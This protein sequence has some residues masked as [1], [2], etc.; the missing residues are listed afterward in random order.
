MG[1]IRAW[2][3][4]NTID[5]LS[6]FQIFKLLKEFGSPENVLGSKTKEIS[7]C[8]GISEEQ[9]NKVMSQL[10]EMDVEREIEK[11]R[12]LGIKILTIEDPS[13]PSYLKEI[14]DPPIL[15]YVKG[16][17]GE[18]LRIGI[19]GSRKAT[20]YGK[21]TSK[22]FAED[23]VS[24]GV[25]I[26]SGMARGIDTFAHLGALEGGGRT[27]AVLGCGIDVP[28]PPENRSLAERISSH[29][30]LVSE[31]L[32]GTRPLR[33]NF[34]RRNRIIAGLCLGLV[35]VEADKKSGALISANLAAEYG[36]EVF[37]VPGR[38]NTRQSNGTNA[39]IQDGAKL[40]R[41]A[42]EVLEE[43]KTY[44]PKEDLS[45]K[46]PSIESMGEK[47]ARVYGLLGKEPMQIDLIANKLHSSISETLT[48]LMDLEIKGL[49]RQLHG[50]QFIRA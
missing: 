23:L 44:L 45:P 5:A 8:L 6:P 38:I 10:D 50:K 47:E 35:V 29:G 13:Y 18:G 21:I 40:V 14:P 26:V 15:I 31:F 24:F 37:A 39:L 34:P 3:R 11:V 28:Y 17:I 25:T 33:Q 49:V 19:V 9:C 41:S 2:V 22:R 32:L 48:L 46:G 27:V 1:D 42:M 16:E 7:S 36:R 20:L 43:F 4:L 30:A 12:E